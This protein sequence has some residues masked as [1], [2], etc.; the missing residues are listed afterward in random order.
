MS[1][2][3][4]QSATRLVQ[5]LARNAARIDFE[6]ETTERT[7]MSDKIPHSGFILGERQEKVLQAFRDHETTFSHRPYSSRFLP[8]GKL[9]GA[10]KVTRDSLVDMKILENVPGKGWRLTDLGWSLAKS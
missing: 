8:M 4:E 5:R 3:K 6:K 2:Q 1:N 10:G 7:N 9:H